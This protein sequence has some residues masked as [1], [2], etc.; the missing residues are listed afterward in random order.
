MH[1]ASVRLQRFR[2]F[3]DSGEIEL[4]RTGVVLLRGRDAVT[5]ES[6]GT[7]KTALLLGIAHVFD[8]VPPG[9]PATALQQWGQDETFQVT[10]RLVLEDGKTVTLMRGKKTVIDY[11]DRQVVGAKS[12]PEELA[13]LVG[14][15]PEILGALTYRVQRQPG[16]FLSATPSEKV[17]FLTRVLGLGAIEEAVKASQEQAKV[18]E[19]RLALAE[20][21]RAMHEQAVRSLHEEVLPPDVII[22]PLEGA[23]SL[24]MHNAADADQAVG[25]TE[26]TIERTR[27]QNRAQKRAELEAKEAAV[28]KAREFLSKLRA[29]DNAKLKDLRAAEASHQQTL[30]QVTA[31]LQRLEAQEGQLVSLRAEIA[32][33]TAGQC[34]TC[35]RE[36]DKAAK[37]REALAAKVASLEAESQ[38]KAIYLQQ[39]AELEAKLAEFSWSPN[40][41]IEQIRQI[42]L[43]LTEELRVLERSVEA[44]LE[45][46]KE[47]ARLRGHQKAADDA[48]HKATMALEVAKAQIQ[49]RRA[50][51]D[52]RQKALDAASVALKSS[53][54]AVA[55]AKTEYNQERDFVA[56]MGRTGFLGLIFD[57]VLQEVAD[58]ANARL[59]RLANVNRVSLLFTSETDKGRRQ[60]QTW[61]DIRG[62]RAK[63]E[64]GPSGGM[65]TS[66]EQVTDLALMSVIQR[67][68]GGRV[69]GWLC[70]DEVFVGQGAA[71]K[72]A[73]LEVLRE[74]AQDRV[75]LVVDHSTEFAQ[76]FAQ[77]IDISFRDGVSS[78][79]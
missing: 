24:A 19:G 16:F 23:Y 13:K 38:G 12:Y 25:D 69:P 1:I 59:G 61:V 64:S 70:L 8:I 34:P 27:L 39:R 56:A 74:F 54:A 33:L 42:E 26:N 41:K 2:S 29:D 52:R 3:F 18:L 66:L 32:K 57:E 35:E 40:P 22:A 36:W 77:T 44:P 55:T 7:G 48:L 75:V 79:A 31:A 72:E 14:Y 28:S 11:G 43:K 6:S 62:H 45:L 21:A 5:G 78:I 47:L 73:A 60:I 37:R 10:V 49:G 65:R 53:E 9:F 4:P 30:R 67:R 63:L 17:E 15:G 50:A 46:Q 58:E 68:T 51:Q 76:N 71:T 20:A